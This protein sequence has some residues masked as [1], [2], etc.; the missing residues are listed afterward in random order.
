MNI[1]SII[2][3]NIENNRAEVLPRRDAI[4]QMGAGV[5]KV[6]LAS[7]P[8]AAAMGGFPKGAQAQLG[9]VNAVLNYALTLEYLEAAYY[10]QGLAAPGLIPSDRRN[11]FDQIGKHETA[12]VDFLRSVL[13]TSAVDRPNFDFTA[14]GAFADVFTNYQTFLA[15]AQ[16]FEDT[17]VRAYKGQAGVLLGNETVLTAALNIHSVEARH[18]SMVR[19]LRGEK[20][21]IVNDQAGGLPA[22]IYA[23]EANTTHGGVDVRTLTDVSDQAVTE[24]WDEPLTS[25]AVLGIAGP[26]I[27]A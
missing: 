27:V 3:S 6:A 11:I 25:E 26:F 24:A 21:W 17:G 23:G 20:G 22:A 19:R 4:A 7:I 8:F 5:W 9:D 12:H 14:G 13:G 16:A 15:L 10:E 2:R 18:A 1:E